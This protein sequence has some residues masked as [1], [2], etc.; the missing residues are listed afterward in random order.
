MVRNS[1]ASVLLNLS[2]G[3]DHLLNV[4]V[5]RMA[6]MLKDL[7]V[8][9]SIKNCP[10]IDV[11]VDA[12]IRIFKDIITRQLQEI[13]PTVLGPMVENKTREVLRGLPVN[14]THAPNITNGKMELPVTILPEVPTGVGL[15]PEDASLY[16]RPH[17]HW[18]IS[19]LSSRSATNN[20]LR[21][22]INRSLLWISK[23]VQ[24]EYTTALIQPVFPKLYELC[25]NCTFS[26]TWNVTD[27]AWLEPLKD[28][29]FVFNLRNSVVDVEMLASNGTRV[30]ALRAL[31]S[32]TSSVAQLLIRNGTL[33]IKIPSARLTLANAT[34]PVGPINSTKL[35]ADL[36]W[37]LDDFL[38]PVVN[39]N[40][41]GFSFSAIPKGLLF[42]A[43]ADAVAIGLDAASLYS[44]LSARLKFW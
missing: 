31:L 6:I 19:I 17:P 42:N 32:T 13:I 18:D 35:S 15:P 33:N 1:N 16:N 2:I 9:P 23:P 4:T 26:V 24:P 5:G 11:V 25:P 43:T 3:T 21:F 28:G 37:I 44:L 14:F 20:V 22:L 39:H 7:D 40:Q 29:G 12:I 8:K 34:S 41:Q 27:A 38:L 30:D 10:V 36:Q